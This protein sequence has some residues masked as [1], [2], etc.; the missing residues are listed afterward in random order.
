MANLRYE[1]FSALNDSHEDA[2]SVVG[3]CLEWHEPRDH[4][5]HVSLRKKIKFFGLF[6][7]SN[8]GG[9]YVPGLE[10]VGS[11]GSRTRFAFIFLK[12]LLGTIIEGK[13]FFRVTGPPLASHIHTGHVRVS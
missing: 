6:F 2:C 7:I 8:N 1:F 3:Q 11:I 13:P 4:Q 5:M 9:G 12:F 10:K